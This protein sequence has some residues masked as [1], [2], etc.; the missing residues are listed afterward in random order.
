MIV[1][2]L[3]YFLV[4]LFAFCLSV[5]GLVVLTARRYHRPQLQKDLWAIIEQ[6]PFGYL[7]LNPSQMYEQA[8]ACT[9]HLLNLPSSTG[10]ISSTLFTVRPP[11]D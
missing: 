3:K 11:R 6:A 1:I 9:R 8:N 10:P 5:I 2:D 7:V 4:G